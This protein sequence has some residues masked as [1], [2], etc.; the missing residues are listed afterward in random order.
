MVFSLC[1]I[2]AL[3]G[4]AGHCL[5]LVVNYSLVKRAVW[6]QCCLISFYFKHCFHC[7]LTLFFFFL[8]TKVKKGNLNIKSKR[9][10]F[11]LLAYWRQVKDKKAKG[12]QGLF[13]FIARSLKQL[14]SQDVK[15]NT[16]IKPQCWVFFS[17][18]HFTVVH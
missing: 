5:C 18:G 14:C 15:K 17:P 2:H 4:G 6:M 12:E 10:E 7:V 16:S 1:H 8:C 11:W 9:K 13:F 3:S